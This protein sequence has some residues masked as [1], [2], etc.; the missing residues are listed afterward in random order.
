MLFFFGIL[1]AV[2]VAKIEIY[3]IRKA[4][5]VHCIDEFLIARFLEVRVLPEAGGSVTEI[6]V[7][8]TKPSWT[9]SCVV[10]ISAMILCRIDSMK[11][12][13]MDDLLV[14]FRLGQAVLGLQLRRQPSEHVVKDVEI[15]LASVL[16]H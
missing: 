4:N 11:L 2:S 5:H 9:P 12:T 7:K 14:T 15:L 8:T 1:I 6:S 13:I 10:N 16:T 3:L